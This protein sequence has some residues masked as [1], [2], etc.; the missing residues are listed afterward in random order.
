MTLWIALGLAILAAA[1]V[2]PGIYISSR[3]DVE[4]E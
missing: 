3:A 2:L 1:L 4:G